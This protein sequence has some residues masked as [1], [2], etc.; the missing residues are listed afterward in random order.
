MN[1]LDSRH[2]LFSI[3]SQIFECYTFDFE[4][5]IRSISS[6]NVEITIVFAIK[7]H[8]FIM[9]RIVPSFCLHLYMGVP[10]NNH[11][12]PRALANSTDL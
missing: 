6:V 3:Q 4:F 8:C 12:F 2:A 5:Q 10:A 1:R 9:Q 7:T 11:F